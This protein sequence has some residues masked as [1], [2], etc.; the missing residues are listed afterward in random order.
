VKLLSAI[1]MVLSIICQLVGTK[2]SC[3]EIVSYGSWKSPITSDMIVGESVLIGQIVVDGTTIYWDE[4]HPKEDGRSVVL[5]RTPE[6][7]IET[8]TPAFS[9]PQRPYFNV[10]TRVHEYGGGA[11][12][13]AGG[14]LYFSNFKDQRLYRQEPGRE[15]VPVTAEAQMFY[16]DGVIDGDH[17]RMFCVRED[18]SVEGEA[19]NTL[20]CLDLT[21]GSVTV[22]A[23]GN[24]FYAFPR[25]NH[26]GTKLVWTT[27][28]HP[29]MPW[30]QTELWVGTVKKDGSVSGAAKIAGGIGE[31]ILQPQWSPDG[32][33]FFISDRNGW[34]NIHAW[35]GANVKPLV[36]M[37]A[38]FAS[39]QWVFGLSSYTIVSSEQIICTYFKDGT[40]H[41]ASID[42]GTG[43]MKEIDTPYTDIQN[44][45]SIPGAVVFSGGS[46]TR[47]T[48]IVKFDTTTCRCEVLYRSAKLQMDE[49]YISVP[50]QI[51]YPTKDNRTAYGIFY[52][53]KNRDYAAPGEE[54]PPLLV[55][56]HGGPT[57]AAG[58]S[59]NIDLQYWT[60]RGFAVLDVNYGGSSGYGRAYRD[61]LKGKWGIVDVDD[62]VNGAKYLVQQGKVDGDK[63]AIRGGSAGGYT[64]LAC[65]VFR[66]GVFKAGAS[67][68]GVSEL[69]VL[70]KYTHKFESC[71]L[72]G[73][74]GHYRPPVD[75]GDPYFDRSPI[76]FADRIVAPLI[77]FQGDEDKIVPPEQSRMMVDALAKKGLPHAYLEF[78]GESHGFRKAENIIR[79]LEA[80]LYFYSKIF[81]FEPADEIEPVSI[82]NL[83]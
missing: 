75:P 8:I 55:F 28:S 42:T 7:R 82:Q 78:K 47:P 36:Q 5:Q 21:N 69:G 64:T 45:K 16:A 53:P 9:D 74:I 1:S 32:T 29:F 43:G 13:V 83:K 19:V 38:E 71:Y 35:D 10:R 61:Q 2:A 14:M 56:T 31:S 11:F 50:E 79:S 49:G 39:P 3:S 73:L 22:I 58:A 63:L 62:A 30:D 81:G 17:K 51:E 37:E 80:E 27:W 48:E 18:H 4:R 33:L 24:D 72:E 12:T 23:S 76:Y 66:G 20:I 77:L 57:A 65:L 68:Y 46:H 6:G 60:S 67:Y 70:A 52:A 54:K 40:W 44:L 25:L 59:F 34:W 41:L 15:P 26:S